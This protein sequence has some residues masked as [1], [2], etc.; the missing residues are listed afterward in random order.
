MP[1]LN[2]TKVLDELRA[3]HTEFPDLRFG[4]AIQ[5][6]I[7]E[8]KRKP[9]TDFSDISSKELLASLQSFRENTRKTRLD[10]QE[11]STRLKNLRNRNIRR[12]TR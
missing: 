10:Y 1:D 3:I 9:N 5:I 6:A 12:E 7:D 11:R 8:R 4:Q 2:F